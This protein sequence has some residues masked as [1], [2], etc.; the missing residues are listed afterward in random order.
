MG[1]PFHVAVVN[2]P[3]E[4]GKA[5]SSAIPQ[6]KI[7]VHSVVLLK[8]ASSHLSSLFLAAGTDVNERTDGGWHTELAALHESLKLAGGAAAHA[9]ILA[10]RLELHPEALTRNMAFSGDLLGS[11]HKST[12]LLDPRGYLVPRQETFARLMVSARWM[13]LRSPGSVVWWLRQKM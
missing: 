2:E 1:R 4:E 11:E 8:A 7:P 13:T 3:R 10:E 9:D 5:G 6:N 12:A